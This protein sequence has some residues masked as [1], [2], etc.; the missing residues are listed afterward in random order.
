MA[1]GGG[2]SQCGQTVNEA[3]VVDGSKHLN[4][5]LELDVEGGRCVVEPG[6]VL[7]DLNRAAQ[8]ARPVV[9]GRRVH[10]RRARPSAAWPAIIPAAG[11]RCATARCATTCIP[12]DAMLADG[13]KAHFGRV[14][15]NLSELSSDTPLAALAAR[16]AALGAARGRRRSRRASPTCSA[17]SAATISTR[18]FRTRPATTSPICSSARK[19]RSPIRPKIELKLWP[20]IG[21]KVLGACHFGSFYA[22]DG[23]RPASG[24]AEA[25]RGRT[26][27]RDDAGAGRRDRD[28]PVRRS[29]RFVRGKPAAILL[30]EF[31][32]D[33]EENERRLRL[34]QEMMGDLGFGWD[35]PGAQWGGVVEVRDAGLQARDR[36]RPHLRPQ[37]HDVDE[38][39]RQAGLLRRGLRGAAG[40]ISP[41]TPTA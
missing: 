31:A 2:T 5:V 1:R 27:R 15:H 19:A 3:I 21:K 20:V 40:R 25:D 32:E 35:K 12:I 30:V 26:G 10:R 4:R 17:A 14:D 7:D 9:P 28:V 23:C 37:H 24:E 36:R 18:W 39:G 22:G 34:L 29:E 13:A 38:A 11:A 33:D 6:I 8:E 41:T 16:P